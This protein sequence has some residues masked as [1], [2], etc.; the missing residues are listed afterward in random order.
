MTVSAMPASS[1][2]AEPEA[3]LKGKPAAQWLRLGQDHYAAGRNDDAFAAFQ[4]GLAAV[5]AAPAG[6][7][8]VETTAELHSKLGNVGMRRGDLGSAAA[9]YKSAL[10]LVP[11]RSDR[12]AAGRH[13]VLS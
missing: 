5:A 3:G 13:R 9:H 4:L 10:R 1:P 6:T 11:G 7:S 2:G 8:P 12:K